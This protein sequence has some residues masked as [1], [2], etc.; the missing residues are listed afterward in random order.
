[1]DFSLVSLEMSIN[2]QS[3]RT[4]DNPLSRGDK[5]IARSRDGLSVK[6]HNVHGF[7]VSCNVRKRH[8]KAHCHRQTAG[9]CRRKNTITVRPRGSAQ[10]VRVTCQRSWQSDGP[11]CRKMSSMKYSNLVETSAR[12]KRDGHSNRWFIPSL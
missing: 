9:L 5:R 10:P 8:N 1:M 6:G 3:F 4:K 11:P 2:D 12:S 7:T